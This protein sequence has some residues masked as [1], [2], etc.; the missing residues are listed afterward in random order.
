MG[1]GEEAEVVR[2]S[3]VVNVHYWI[4]WFH[5]VGSIMLASG[6]ASFIHAAARPQCDLCTGVHVLAKT[7][8]ATEE[9]VIQDKRCPMALR[10]RVLA[11]QFV[12]HA[13]AMS[14]NLAHLQ[15]CPA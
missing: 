7:S 14:S 12:F 4:Y 3:A 2:G 5:H 8:I 9:S 15:A 1:V 6:I 10:N 11:I 13:L